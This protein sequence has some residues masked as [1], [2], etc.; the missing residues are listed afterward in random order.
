MLFKS[1]S[2]RAMAEVAITD[3]KEAEVK[4]ERL[5][6]RRQLTLNNYT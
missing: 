5:P 1:Y 4:A 6:K 3:A 2:G